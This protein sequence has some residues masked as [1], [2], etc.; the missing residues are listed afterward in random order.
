[1]PLIV[2]VESPQGV[3]Q[4]AV[5]GADGAIGIHPLHVAAANA[6]FRLNAAERA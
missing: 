5:H 4:G 1:L 3:A 2:P 6:V